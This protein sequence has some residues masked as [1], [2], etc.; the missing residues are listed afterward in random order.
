MKEKIVINIEGMTCA[1]CAQIN[2]RALKKAEGVID[3]SVNFA[4]KKASVEFDPEK[5]DQKKIENIIIK[6][7][8]KVMNMDMDMDE[9]EHSYHG[10][11]A[12]YEI[13]K[14][15]NLFLWSSIFST[16]LAIQMISKIEFGGM[17]FGQPLT[18]LINLVLATV[19]VF[20]LGFQF[21]RSAFL[22]AFNSVLDN[23]KHRI[24]SLVYS[25]KYCVPKAITN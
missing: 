10:N 17:Y 14:K 24:N 16:P 13:N 5:I 6:S 22:K 7:G 12:A 4:T 11:A 18:M 2:E 23:S 8:Y 25:K 20:I 19:V 3:A 21:H 15:R 1:S 9:M